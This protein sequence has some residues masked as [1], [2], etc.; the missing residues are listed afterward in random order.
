MTST[1]FKFHVGVG[2]KKHAMFRTIGDK[3]SKYT[4]P[5]QK[6]RKA[7]RSLKWSSECLNNAILG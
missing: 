3:V 5:T 1:L 4:F 7:A 2:E 6:L